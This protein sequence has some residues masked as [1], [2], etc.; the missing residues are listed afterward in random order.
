MCS[1]SWNAGSP[2]LRRGNRAA[3]VLLPVSGVV[4][5]T[6]MDRPMDILHRHGRSHGAPQVAWDEAIHPEVQ[7]AR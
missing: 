1:A 2:N 7:V 3:R 6:D 4:R 5:P